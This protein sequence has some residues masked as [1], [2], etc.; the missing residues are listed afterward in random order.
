VNPPKNTAHQKPRGYNE[1]ILHALELID[2]Y[3]S[4]P[5]KIM[6]G[7]NM[8]KQLM[9][10]EEIMKPMT[11]NCGRHQRDWWYL[12]DGLSILSII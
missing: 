5:F 1:E 11:M 4:L 9:S 2:K 7:V 3:Y 8:K 6:E 10:Y 12:L